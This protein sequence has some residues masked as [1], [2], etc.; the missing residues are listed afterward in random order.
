MR[1]LA[2]PAALAAITLAASVVPSAAGFHEPNGNFGLER[3]WDGGGLI[4]GTL[5]Q[6]RRSPWA[7]DDQISFEVR[8]DNSGYLWASYDNRQGTCAFTA[9]DLPKITLIASTPY[10][11][12]FVRWGKDGVCRFTDTWVASKRLP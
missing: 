9:A 6:F 11:Q 5:E 1:R 2:F 10:V 12:F 7:Y 4:A 8:A 3:Y